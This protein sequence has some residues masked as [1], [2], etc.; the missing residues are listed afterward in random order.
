[1]LRLLV[2]ALCSALLLPLG[3]AAQPVVLPADLG[4][5]LD[6]VFARF[7]DR[8]PGCAVAFGRGG[9]VVAQRAYGLANLEYAVANTPQTIFEAGSVAKQFTAGAIVLLAL[10]GAL[11]LDD[12]VRRY[13]PELPAYGRPITI[14]HLLNHTR[15][16]CATGVASRAS[17]AGA[18]VRGCTRTITFSTS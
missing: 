9:E 5:R 10:D 6:G 11:S 12:D 18:A 3:A 16:G 13:V 15:A 2:L 17:R 4:R 8:S 7:A 1:M 14:R